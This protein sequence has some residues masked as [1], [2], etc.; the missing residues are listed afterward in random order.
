MFLATT[1]AGSGVMSTGMLIMW[2]VIM[3][4]NV[5]LGDA[6]TLFAVEGDIPKVAVFLAMPDADKGQAGIQPVLYLKRH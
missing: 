5:H 3:F 4:G 6:V 2:L 1:T